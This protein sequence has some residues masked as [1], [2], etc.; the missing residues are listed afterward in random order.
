MAQQPLSILISGAGI[1]GASLALML[2]R[3]PSFK[4]KPIITLIERSPVPRTTGQA[5]DIRGPAV[6]VIRSLGLEQKIKDRHTTE[7]GIAFVDAEGRTVAQVDSTGNPEYQTATSEYEILRGELAGLLLENIDVGKETMAAE[8]RVVYG[9]SIKALEE[10]D[11]GV[12][13]QFK[14]GKVEDGKFDVVVGADGYSSGTRALIFDEQ[15]SETAVKPMGMYIGYYTIPRIPS[16]DDL[17]RWYHAAGGL[18]IHLR[19]H[20]NKTTMGVYLTVTGPSRAKNPEIEVILAQG[21]DAEK[22]YLRKTFEHL[23]WQS[24]RFVDGLDTSSDLYM[25][26]IAMVTTPHWTSNRC[27]VVG[28]AAFAMMGVG[29]SFAMIGAYIIAGELSKIES[30][31]AADVSAALKSYEQIMRPLVAK[32]DKAPLGFPQTFNPQ[33]QLGVTIL[34][35]TT[36]VACAMRIPQ[37]IQKVFAGVG[38]RDGW[39]LPD[40]GWQG[41]LGAETK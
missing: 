8:V 9:E 12:A 6:K 30:N 13:V 25:H 17:W 36:R 5:I 14:N 24:K 16:D 34:R 27:A 23:G 3:H 21:V 29:T 22:A 39:K 19:P 4:L 41:Q 11:D 31:S 38:E 26:S 2:A 18:A 10:R 32:H 28:D 35:T 7:T 20:R 40:Y 15:V 33:T 1:A 37:I